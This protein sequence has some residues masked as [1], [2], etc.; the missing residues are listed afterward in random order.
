VGWLDWLRSLLAGGGAAENDPLGD[1]KS[2]NGASSF[3]LGWDAPGS[4]S[5]VSAVLTVVTPPSVS[6]L[7]FW[8]LQ[9]SFAG[10]GGAGAHVGL[11]WLADRS[12]AANW[13]GYGPGGGELAAA[14]GGGPNTQ[15]FAWEAGVPYTL[16]V[17]RGAA[18]WVGT[19]E[20]GGRTWT[21]E[22]LVPGG[23][24]LSSP[25][26]W[27]EVFAR[28]DHPSVVVRWSDF[29]VDDTPV[30]RASVNYQAASD[31]GCPNTDS[32]VDG[33]AFVQTTAVAR[34]NAQGSVLEIQ[35]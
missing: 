12:H 15:P 25:V 31:G 35:P 9:V 11:Q 24:A 2:A 6:R 22:L 23:Q 10:S 34:A 20:G 26:V 33:A 19:V 3:H 4:F 13:G 28:C 8:A 18:G 14:P 16:S 5:S 27:S 7:Y 29:M 30:A 17:R 21:R 1:P 32:S